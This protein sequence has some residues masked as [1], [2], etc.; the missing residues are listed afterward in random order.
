MS[1]S[2]SISLARVGDRPALD[3]LLEASRADLLSMASQALDPRIQARIRAS[4]VVQQTCLSAIREFRQF[5][6]ADP[7]Q[8]HAW[9]RQIHRRNILNAIRAERDTLGRSVTREQSP[10][11]DEA[12]SD[13]DTPSQFAAR[14]EEQHRLRMALAALDPEDAELLRL[15]FHEDWSVQQ[16]CSHWQLSRSALAWKLQKAL[17]RIRELVESRTGE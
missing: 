2:E 16:L 14:N 12:L 5:H 11:C 6:G 9:L 17:K 3:Q 7:A 15:R 1:D 13:D 8:F 4:D 10:G